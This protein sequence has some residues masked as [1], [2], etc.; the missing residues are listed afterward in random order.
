MRYYICLPII[1]AIKPK[2]KRDEKQTIVITVRISYLP[3][4]Y[5]IAVIIAATPPEIHHHLDL[6][7]GS[8]L[9]DKT[10]TVKPITNPKNSA[11]FIICL[12]YQKPLTKHLF[13]ISSLSV[14]SFYNN[15]AIL[16]TSYGYITKSIITIC[17]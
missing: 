12:P 4:K 11:I 6:M 8:I 15:F 1:S 2:I 7:L 17:R 5:K 16:D 3:H 9:L 10:K 14:D 13:Y